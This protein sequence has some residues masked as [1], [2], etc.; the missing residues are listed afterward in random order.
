MSKRFLIFCSILILF[1]FLAQERYFTRAQLDEGLQA[2][3]LDSFFEDNEDVE[4]EIFDE[5]IFEEEINSEDNSNI[6]N[7]EIIDI[8]KPQYVPEEPLPEF[9][10]KSEMYIYYARKYL[11][12][13]C[14]SSILLV[15]I[16]N[17]FVGKKVNSKLVSMWIAEA[18]PLLKENFFHLGFGEESNVSISQ[19]KYHEYEFFASGRDYCHYVF[20]HL[21]TKKRQDVIGGSLFGLIW[22]EK[23]KI[24]F[25]I[26][27]D[28]DLPLEIMICRKQNVKTTRQEMPNINQLIAPLPLK[29]LQNTQLTVLADSQESAE[30]VFTKKFMNGFEK[31][32]KYLEFLHVTDQRVYTNYP[33]VLKGEI[34]LGDSP[35][36]YKDSVALLGLILELIDHIAK[37]VKL[38]SRVLE[39]AKKLREVEEK[40]REKVKLLIK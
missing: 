29:G 10:S 34:L 38:P 2:E 4:A 3:D 16:L 40:K 22:P 9:E 30:I 32:E 24:I 1:C 17:I 19:I 7:E 20:M 36:E 18:L 8:P 11:A 37:P 25:D 28:V 23:D 31:Y 14:L 21:I 26:P 5:P 27:I 13:I 12:E 6:I 39:K 35:S 33:L 15:Y